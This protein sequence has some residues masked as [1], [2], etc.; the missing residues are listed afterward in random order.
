MMPRA[1]PAAGGGARALAGYRAPAPAC[2]IIP[3][4]CAANDSARATPGSRSWHTGTQ[5]LIYVLR[6]PSCVYTRMLTST[7]TTL[8]T[9]AVGAAGLVRIA[10]QVATHC[11]D[12]AADC[13]AALQAALNDTVADELLIPPRSGT[14][15]GTWPVQPLLIAF[16]NKAIT[17]STT[18]EARTD[19]FH[20]LHDMLVTVRGATNVSLRGDPSGD[21]GE[22]RMRKQEYLTTDPATGA[23]LYKHSEWRHALGIYS[24]SDVHIAH[25][26][27]AWAGGDGIYVDGLTS[28]TI[29]GVHV[30]ESYRN[31]MSIISA[32]GLIVSDCLF[33][34]A[35]RARSR[36][37]AY[38][39]HHCLHCFA[40]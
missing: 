21:P 14:A 19:Y 9:L 39:P 35:S 6:D 31:A 15:S 13:T 22:L 5:T 16:G 1:R 34:S 8:A 29:T 27:I 10:A 38:A 3:T 11:P 12:A 25:L 30:N 17:L 32:T 40:L 37:L 20:G 24:S 26:L 2:Y 23:P 33:A 28:G 4:P 36:A 18:L 7:V